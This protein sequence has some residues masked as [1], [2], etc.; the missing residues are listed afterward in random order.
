LHGATQCR[1]QGYQQVPC[2]FLA[3]FDGPRMGPSRSSRTGSRKSTNVAS[4]S[5]IGDFAGRQRK[6]TVCSDPSQLRQRLLQVADQVVGVL[7]ADREPHE[8]GRTRG[9][10][11]FDARAVLGEALDRSERRRRLNTRR[12]AVKRFAAWSP[13]RTRSDSMPPKPPFICRAAVTCPGCE[14]NPG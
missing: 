11:P 2:P 13:P 12:R 8:I 1:E 3:W 6:S 7:D 4:G 10:R 5:R 14:G 9:P